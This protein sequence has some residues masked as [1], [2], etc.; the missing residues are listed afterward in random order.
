MSNEEQSTQQDWRLTAELDVPEAKRTLHELVGRL[1]GGAGV[2]AGVVG[3]IQESVPHD[4]VVTHDGK[5]L[6]AY[7]A[8]EATIAAARRAI[9]DVLARE[10]IQA[11]SIRVSMWDEELDRWRQTDPPPSAEEQE[12]EE[13]ERRDGETLETRTLVA[14][15]GK[16]VRAD[17]ELSMLNFAAELG[18]EC[19]LVEH[20]HLLTTQVGF[21]VTGPKRKLDEFAQGLAAEERTTI[22]TENVVMLSPL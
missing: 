15:S 8:D 7:A 22:R 9:E 1:R 18:I 19:T 12:A 21:T 10:S 14:S 17:L 3:E 4:V 5:L 2:D 11:R 6:F 20:P 13:G 16:L